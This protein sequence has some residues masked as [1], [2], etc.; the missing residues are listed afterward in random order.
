MSG[1]GGALSLRFLGVG[2]AQASALG[3]SSAVLQRGDAPLLLID[4][5]IGA[6]DRYRDVYGALPEA[7]FVTHTHLDHV[8]DFEAWFYR[9]AFAAGARLP[10]VYVPASVVPLLQRRVAD[11]PNW[12]AEGGRN[13]WDVFQLVPVS[14]HF[15]HAGLR[16]AVFPVRHHAPESAFGLALAGSF[17]YTGDTRPIPEWLQ[18]HARHGEWIFHDCAPEP[19]PSHTGLPDLEREYAA[20]VRARLVLY[21]YPDQPAFERMRGQGYRVATPGAVFEL[22]PPNDDA[23]VEG[24]TAWSSR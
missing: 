14:D 16:F 7:V 17:L 22:P 19:N 11:F 20:G 2:S 6:L 5:G 8:G 1:P 21:H 4:C 18:Q 12:V 10:R 24:W 23:C 9:L 15:W 13:F 3:S